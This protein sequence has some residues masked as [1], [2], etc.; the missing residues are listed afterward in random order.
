MLLDMGIAGIGAIFGAILR[1]VIT[2]YGKK[3]WAKNFPWATI[4]INLSGALILGFIFA[5]SLKINYYMLIG[6]GMMG[7]YTTFS[8]LNVELLK[9]YTHKSYKIFL[10]YGL[11]SYLGGL[12]LVFL[13]FMLGKLI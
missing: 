12:I 2:N 1:Y 4:L 6:T 5:L 3:H 9:E 8:T 10:L 11:S 13:G 7:G